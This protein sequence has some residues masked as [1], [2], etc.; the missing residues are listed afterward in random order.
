MFT[1]LKT[2]KM[3]QFLDDRDVSIKY[4]MMMMIMIACE[5]YVP[6]S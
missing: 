2:G 5:N 3:E 1:V 4:I 6:Q